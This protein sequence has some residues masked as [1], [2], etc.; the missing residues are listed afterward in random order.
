MEKGKKERADTVDIRVW[1]GK[2]LD[3]INGEAQDGI[4]GALL[5]HWKDSW[6]SH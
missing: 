4:Q 3:G 6:G 1:K 2:D 5:G